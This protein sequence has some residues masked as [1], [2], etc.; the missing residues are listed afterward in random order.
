MYTCMYGVRDKAQRRVSPSS[1]MKCIL[2]LRKAEDGHR[3]HQVQVGLIVVALALQ[4]VRQH[5][6]ELVLRCLGCLISVISSSHSVIVSA[7]LDQAH[8]SENTHREECTIRQAI[9]CVQSFANP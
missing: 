2:K 8:M 7:K 1:L 5:I 6:V 3:D 4:P 9:S